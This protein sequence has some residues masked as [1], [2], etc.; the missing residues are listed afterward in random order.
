MPRALIR[1]VDDNHAEIVSALRRLG[2][3][4]QSTATIG[5]GFPDICFAKGNR[6]YAWIAEIKD[7]SKVPSKR[8]LTPDE[9]KFHA[10]CAGRSTYLKASTTFSL[11]I[12]KYRSVI[13]K[14][15]PRNTKAN[16]RQS[17]WSTII[18]AIKPSSRTLF[19][20]SRWRMECL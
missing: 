14:Y 2:Y 13:T 17:D 4:V 1:K 20:R 16:P 19:L 3:S 18:D 11:S 9:V 12:E 6:E 15:G 5:K 8:K 7:G 10:A